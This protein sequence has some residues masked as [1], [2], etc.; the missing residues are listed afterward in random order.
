MRISLEMRGRTTT[1]CETFLE[2]V[3]KSKFNEGAPIQVGACRL[4][5]IGGILV[6]M[7]VA[8][9]KLVMRAAA[10]LGTAPEQL[11]SALSAHYG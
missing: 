10:F 2:G 6:V 5:R 1:N 7:A 11:H 4:L 3:E 9:E 8:I